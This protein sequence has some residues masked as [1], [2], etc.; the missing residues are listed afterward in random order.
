MQIGRPLVRSETGQ[1]ES[2]KKSVAGVERVC[3]AQE[4]RTKIEIP[5][6]CIVQQ[7]K[8]WK[9]D[10]HNSI[11]GITSPLRGGKDEGFYAT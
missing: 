5:V 6:S 2:K 9:E 11:V 3:Q 7:Q 1:V 8:K 10:Q 4:P